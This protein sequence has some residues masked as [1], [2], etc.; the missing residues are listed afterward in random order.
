L[1]VV[2]LNQTAG[3]AV[4]V[5]GA[6]N[7]DYGKEVSTP[8]ALVT[9]NMTAADVEYSQVGHGPVADGPCAVSSKQLMEFDIVR[10]DKVAA[11]CS[12]EPFLQA[13][14]SGSCGCDMYAEGPADFANLLIGLAGLLPLG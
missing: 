11:H 7:P 12:N 3:T 10:N 1:D 2:T 4:D 6:P 9:K 8:K 13:K 5:E 14:G